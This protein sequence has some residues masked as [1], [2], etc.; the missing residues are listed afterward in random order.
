MTSA[1]TF[2]AL[3]GPKGPLRHDGFPSRSR[4]IGVAVTNSV[5]NGRD[6]HIMSTN[7]SG[8]SERAMTHSHEGHGGHRG[9]EERQEHPAT[10]EDPVCGTKA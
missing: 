3:D 10:V 5:T 2:D 4:L 7:R 1:I 8:Y 6:R 9:H